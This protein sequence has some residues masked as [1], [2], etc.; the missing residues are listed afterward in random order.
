[1]MGK[2]WDSLERKGL[3]KKARACGPRAAHMTGPYYYFLIL[4]RDGQPIIHPF[5][6]FF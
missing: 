3:K 1:M 5:N 6:V 4:L 2:I